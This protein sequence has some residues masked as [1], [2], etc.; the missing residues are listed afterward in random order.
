MGIGERSLAD[1]DA[2]LYG[3]RGGR[4]GSEVGA[5]E[6][7]SRRPGVIQFTVP[8]VPV[9]QPRQ[10]TRIAKGANGKQYAQNYT[11][12][13][14]PVNAFKATVRH[15]AELAYAGPPLQGPLAVSVVFVMPRPERLIWKTRPM[16][17]VPYVAS[18]NDWDNLGKAVSD[19]LNKRLW[20]DDGQLCSVTVERWIAAGD[21][22]PH[23]V[24]S[25]REIGETE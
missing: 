19:A 15:A 13:G 16:P 14:S 12:T 8:A 5:G 20:N 17:R 3:R 7:D 4:V 6:T 11:P 22:Q 18:R 2:K 9:A 23:C 1:A 10:R 25:I 24:V 21:E